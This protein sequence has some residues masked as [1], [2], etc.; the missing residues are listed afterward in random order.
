VDRR[1]SLDSMHQLTVVYP[2]ALF[3]AR[4]NGT[5]IAEFVVDTAGHVEDGSFA[6]VSS[7]DPLFSEAVRQAVQ[8]ATY[9][10]AI[11]RGTR[12][13]QVVQQPFDFTTHA[14]AGPGG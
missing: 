5:V 8:G 10:P 11:R 7:T 2:A 1:A 12:V 6:I 4:V 13:R 14:N 9:T 3:A